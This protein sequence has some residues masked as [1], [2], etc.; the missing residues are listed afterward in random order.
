MLSVSRYDRSGV[1]D[2]RAAFE[3]QLA[4]WEAV[5]ANASDESLATAHFAE[6]ESRFP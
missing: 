6:I 2:C 5:A 3:A 4:A 1:D